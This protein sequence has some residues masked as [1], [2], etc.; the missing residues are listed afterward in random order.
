[1]KAI[2]PRAELGS[3]KPRSSATIASTESKE[4]AKTS[5]DDTCRARKKRAAQLISAA[6][7]T[8]AL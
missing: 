2:E 7:K 5:S 8:N 4:I 1:M 6:L 3:T